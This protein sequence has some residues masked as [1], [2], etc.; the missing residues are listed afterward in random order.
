M[1]IIR[2]RSTKRR[3]LATEHCTDK[4]IPID[5]GLGVVDT[6]FMSE[7]HSNFSDSDSDFWEDLEER[8]KNAG[9]AVKTWVTV[10]L[11]WR[12]PDVS[13]SMEIQVDVDRNPPVRCLPPVAILR[14]PHGKTGRPGIY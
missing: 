14:R 3:Q 11:A 12:S 6:D 10:G 8:R 5:E 4:G 2:Q 13:E 1:L 9:F 7:A